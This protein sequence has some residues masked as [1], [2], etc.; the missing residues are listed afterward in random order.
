MNKQSLITLAATSLLVTSG[1]AHADKTDHQ[2]LYVGAG[3][4]LL[5]VDGNEDFDKEDN[6]VN[7]YAGV[8][9]NQIL[10]A[11][12]GY[13]DFGSYGNDVF[14]SAVDGYTL[15]LKAGI[16]VHDKVTLYARGGQLWW[17]SD[18]SATDDKQDL[19]GEDF[20]YGIGASFALSNSW[21]L[22]L[23]YTRYDLEFERDEIGIL[24]E[25]DDFDTEVD[26]A[27]IALQYTF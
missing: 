6:S 15:A 25:V 3:Y 21:D 2:G 19:D 7:A 24:A 4:G 20:F 16:P 23:E 18:L 22:R 8:Q 26:Q 1:L 13:I 11:E 14:S 9:F 12:A 27:G 10:S 5:K 17:Q